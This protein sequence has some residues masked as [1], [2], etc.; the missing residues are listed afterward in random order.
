MNVIKHFCD[1]CGN[2]AKSLYQ[3]L[4]RVSKSASVPDTLSLEVCHFCNFKI[5][6]AAL[7][8]FD[9]IKEASENPH[10]VKEDLRKGLTADGHGVHVKY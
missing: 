8:K 3:F 5:M 1:A 9:E 7:W 10:I 6:M 4:K 2:E